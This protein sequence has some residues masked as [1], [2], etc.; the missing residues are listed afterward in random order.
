MPV[1]TAKQ[2]VSVAAST[3][4]RP[5]YAR[6]VPI[7]LNSAFVTVLITLTDILSPIYPRVLES[8][9]PTSTSSSSL[10]KCGPRAVCHTWTSGIKRDR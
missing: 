4:F 9:T 3:R 6:V 10:A 7:V 8:G 5:S 2:A 1:S